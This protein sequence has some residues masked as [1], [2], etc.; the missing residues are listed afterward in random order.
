S[1]REGGAREAWRCEGGA[2]RAGGEPLPGLALLRLAQGKGETGAAAI[3]RAL[4]ETI[5]PLRR[6]V[7]LP[8]WVEIALAI[9]DRDAARAA[10]GE[11]DEIA[12]QQRSE[13]L[14]ATA[15]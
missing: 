6:A 15:A 14:D 4:D 12:A 10:C 8:A 1:R 5:L 2:P 13:L 7:L 9:G 3:R 11:L